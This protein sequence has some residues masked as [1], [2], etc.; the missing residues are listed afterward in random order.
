MDP[1]FDD[2]SPEYDR[3]ETGRWPTPDEL[4][5]RRARLTELVNELVTRMQDMPFPSV[6]RE[7]TTPNGR[8][9]LTIERI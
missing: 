6:S 3:P 5:A 2:D 7:V 9:R 1:L 8:F 4:A